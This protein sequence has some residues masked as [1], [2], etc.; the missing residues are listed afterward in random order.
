LVT[1]Y[2][3]RL[4]WQIWFA[5]F[6]RP[7]RNPWLAH[8]M[9]KLLIGEPAAVELLSSDPFEGRGP[10]RW[11]KAEMYRYEFTDPGQQ[12]WWNRKRIGRYFPPVSADH[13]GLQTVV[14]ELTLS[15]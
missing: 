1:P 9:Y 8:L 14:E 5:A 13:P 10:P 2:H 6:Q 12:G 3:Y 11:I 7:S 4:D 15:P